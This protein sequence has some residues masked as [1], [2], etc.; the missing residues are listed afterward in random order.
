MKYS[1]SGTHNFNVIRSILYKDCRKR[2]GHE[3]YGVL[4]RHFFF[5]TFNRRLVAKM[6]CTPTLPSL[7]FFSTSTEKIIYLENS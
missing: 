4:F 5:L 2:L 6:N 7:L 3:I 1:T